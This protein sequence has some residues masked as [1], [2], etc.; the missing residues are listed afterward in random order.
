MDVKVTI[1]TIS[2]KELS[3]AIAEN[4][5][6][7]NSNP[8]LSKTRASWIVQNPD[9]EKEDPCLV[10]AKT[11]N[12]FVGHLQLISSYINQ[13]NSSFKIFFLQRWWVKKDLKNQNIGSLLYLEA[14]KNTSGKLIV[15]SYNNNMDSFYSN[16]KFFNKITPSNLY[17]FFFHTDPI[18]L[19]SRHKLFKY[20]KGGLKIGAALSSFTFRTLNASHIKKL[21][22][23]LSYDYFAT[24]D[25]KVF[26]SIQHLIKN[27]LVIKSLDQ[28][29]WKLSQNQFTPRILGQKDRYSIP[30]EEQHQVNLIVNCA[31]FEGEELLGSFS[32]INTA[33]R[34][35]VKLFLTKNG[36]EKEV[37]ASLVDNLYGLKKYTLSTMDKKLKDILISDYKYLYM[38]ENKRNMVVFKN[39]NIKFNPTILR[40]MD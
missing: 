39:K 11:G 38:H 30:F 21:T 25:I 28:L 1:S 23:K 17:T 27:D 34:V 19:Y 31:V 18:S 15:K 10:I 14:L 9:A 5:Y 29:N 24:Y 3:L 7:L 16:R 40:G 20:L 13:E 22:K 37:A 12:E 4:S 2:V 32:F 26:E 33:H 35:D 6:W 8:P 36:Y